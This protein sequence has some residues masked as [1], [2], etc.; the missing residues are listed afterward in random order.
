MRVLILGGGAA[1][2]ALAWKLVSAPQVEQIYCSPG[3][4][5]TALLAGRPPFSPE[6]SAEIAQWAFAQQMDLVVVQGM[7]EWVDLLAGVGLAVLGVGEHAWRALGSR[8]SMR[9]LL[10]PRQI[11]CVQGRTFRDLEMAERYLASR[12]LPLWI[13]PDDATQSQAVRVEE[14]LGGFQELARLLS[15]DPEGGVSIE[16]AMPGPEVALALLSDGQRG[17]SCGVSRIYSCRYEGETGP[18]TEGMGAYAPYGAPT[19]EEELMETLG[20]PVL[21]ALAG[22]GLLGPTFVQLRIVLG[23]TGPVLRDLAWGLDDLHAAVVLPRWDV[24]L[25][26]LLQAAAR[27][28]LEGI[29]PAWR[30]GV[31]VAVAMVAEGY[32]GPSPEGQPLPGLYEI[33][34]LVFHHA[35]RL[36]AE[37]SP[38]ALGPLSS[39]LR[40]AAPPRPIEMARPAVT[41]GGRVLLVVGLAPTGAEAR[42]K[43]YQGVAGLTFP[44]CAWRQDIAVEL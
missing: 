32:P 15:L 7:P 1:L 10:Q 38:A 42:S 29:P 16:D 2:H 6:R 12:R 19:L 18:A 14:R 5:G 25:A 22:A 26:G 41:E 28:H 3:N 4:A 8:Q 33:E 27:G 30:P 34:A 24:D 11:P 31:A 43:A 36:Q 35:T 40:P 9:E 20:R 39:W 37:D 23:E 13:R 21:A 17:L 44:H